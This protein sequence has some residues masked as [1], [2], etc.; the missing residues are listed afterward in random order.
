MTPFRADGSAFDVYLDGRP[1]AFKDGLVL[2][3]IALKQD[4]RIRNR[5]FRSRFPFRMAFAENRHPLFGAML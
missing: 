3:P 1:A 2:A 5:A 4:V